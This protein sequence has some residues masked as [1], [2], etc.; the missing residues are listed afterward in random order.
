MSA[1]PHVS[2]RAHVLI[3][4][5]E[6]G[7]RESLRMIL[8][9]RYAVS[10]AGNGNEALDVLRTT[11]VDLVT[12]DLNMPGMRGDELMRTIRSEFPQTEII[13]ITGCGSVETAIEGIR[14]GVFDYLT[15]PFDVVQVSASVERALD[16]HQDR[17]RMVEF[18]GGIGRILG[19]NRDTEIVLEELD[20]S[21]LAQ[22]RVREVLEGAALGPD[23]GRRGQGGPRTIEFL[24][25]LAE[26]I[27]SRDLFMR[28]HARRVTFLADLIGARLCLSRDE[29]ERLQIAAFLHDIGKVGA[30][31]DLLSGEVML[32]PHRLEAIQPHP[33]IGERLL[34][35]LD[36]DATIATVVRHHHERYDGTGYPDGTAGEDIPLGAR[37]IGIVEA[38]D[39]MTCERPYSRTQTHDEALAELL[40]E[41]GRQFDPNLVQIFHELVMS[42]AADAVDQAGTLASV[43]PETALSIQ[44]PGA[45]D[46]NKRGAA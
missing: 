36:L 15:K 27:E 23:T 10:A 22:E 6:Q 24:E 25:V 1:E 8:S 11:E 21:P 5:D 14:H 2:D 13:V 9:G 46:Q 34:R 17:A 37:I 20:A 44:R 12:V 31:S 16:R 43:L 26:T 40:R 19:R 32:E 41:S 3:V 4:D 38:F 29:R 7:P 33:A 28:G 35:P 39:A 45:L 30:P 18:L 42:G